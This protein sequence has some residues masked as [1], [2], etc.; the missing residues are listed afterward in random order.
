MDII[1]PQKLDKIDCHVHFVGGG[2][3]KS[4]SWFKLRTPW[5]KFQARLM[6]KGCGIAPNA[7]YDDLDTI[8]INKL[9]QLIRD[10]SLDRVV[11][12][13]QDIAHDDNGNPLPEKS[14]YFVPND[15]VIEFAKSHKEIIPAISIHPARSDALEELEKCIEHGARIMKILPNVI[16]INCN[17]KRHSKFWSRMADA[18]MILLSHTGGEMTLPV[19][20]KS[21]A[22]P[23]T[24]ELPLELGVTCIAAHSAGGSYPGDKDYTDD[25]LKMFKQYDNLYGDNSALCSLNRNKTIGKILDPE[26]QN[27]IIHGSDYPVPVSGLG[28]WVKGYLPWKD[29]RK[30]KTCDNIL[31]TDYQFKK[32]IGFHEETFTRL[33]QLLN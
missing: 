9:L 18:K 19:L 16:N 11:L 15:I 7:L 5:D 17:D 2:T 14:K 25:L 3:A 22:D 8:Y 23:R 24:L 1:E 33:S 30:W 28:V 13:A 21:Y 29:W 20:N 10:S 12:L 27:R 4:G 32:A 31:E 26:I 6:L